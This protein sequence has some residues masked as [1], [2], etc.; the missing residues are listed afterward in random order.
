MKTHV[1]KDAG[2]PA[3]TPWL[4]IEGRLE[5]RSF[6]DDEGKERGVCEIVASDVQ[7]LSSSRNIGQ[8]DPDAGA[9]EGTPF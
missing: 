1:W 8:P 6:Q 5:Y 3:P 7:F 4:Y 9:P 2:R